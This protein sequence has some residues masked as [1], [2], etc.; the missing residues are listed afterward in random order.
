MHADRGADAFRRLGRILPHGRGFWRF[1]QRTLTSDAGTTEQFTFK[2]LPYG[3]YELLTI[4][5]PGAYEEQLISQFAEGYDVVVPATM[6]ARVQ[7]VSFT[8]LDAYVDVTLPPEP[9]D[10][11]APGIQSMAVTASKEVAMTGDRLQYTVNFACVPGAD[12]AGRTLSFNSYGSRFDIDGVSLSL[13]DTAGNRVEGAVIEDDHIVVPENANILT[14]SLIVTGKIDTGLDAF[15]VLLTIAGPAGNN[16][17]PRFR[18]RCSVRDFSAVI[19]D[20]AREDHVTMNGRGSAGAIITVEATSKTDPSRTTSTNIEVGRYGYW[21]GSVEL[22]VGT[23]ETDI[24]TITIKD[25]GSNVLASGE[26]AYE[27]DTVLP[28]QISIITYVNGAKNITVGYPGSRKDFESLNNAVLQFGPDYTRVPIEVEI[29]F[30]DSDPDGYG[31]TDARRVHDPTLTLSFGSS[32]TPNLYYAFYPVDDK[33]YHYHNTD[34]DLDIEDCHY[35]TKYMA[36]FPA[37]HFGKFGISY[38]LFDGEGDFV[39]PALDDHTD[40]TSYATNILG[41]PSAAA[42]QYKNAVIETG[43]WINQYPGG[44][45]VHEGHY[46]EQ[47]LWSDPGIQISDLDEDMIKKDANPDP[48][49]YLME[50]FEDRLTDFSCDAVMK[51][52]ALDAAEL[53]AKIAE[54]E[55]QDPCYSQKFMSND[56]YLKYVDRSATYSIKYNSDSNTVDLIISTSYNAIYDT[57]AVDDGAGLFEEKGILE[58]GYFV[59]ENVDSVVQNLALDVASEMIS[60][61]T[62]VKG[63]VNDILSKAYAAEGMAEKAAKTGAI[64]KWNSRLNVAGDVVGAGV[65]ALNLGMTI[66]NEVFEDS[67]A[68]INL[69]A[70]T[71]E[72][73]KRMQDYADKLAGKITCLDKNHHNQMVSSEIYNIKDS[74]LNE[75]AAIQDR[76]RGYYKMNGYVEI[77]VTAT[78]FI[79]CPPSV[80]GAA[81][82]LQFLAKEAREGTE[83][84]YAF[85]QLKDM[86][87]CAIKFEQQMWKAFKNGYDPNLCDK[88]PPIEPLPDSPRIKPIKIEIEP[89]RVLDPS[90]VVYE[91]LLSNPVEGVNVEIEYSADGENDWV[92][93]DDAPLYN[94][95]QSSYVTGPTGYY[96]WDVPDGFWRVSYQKD[97]Y[98]GGAKIY[99][100][101]MEVPPIWLDVN[102]PM[103]S[104]DQASAAATRDADGI[105]VV[106]TK[107]VKAE[108]VTAEKLKITNL[109]GDPVPVVFEA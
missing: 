108:D 30:D 24:F 39:L 1:D 71:A 67:K 103:E 6:S 55:A 50:P 73:N 33:T 80:P 10:V 101:V 18:T 81:S 15:A 109:Q 7:N 46:T 37:Y 75:I 61:V 64:A 93:W 51:W 54:L 5:D 88:I 100:D 48:D 60:N 28:T 16:S 41:Y 36:S 49:M 38:E 96:Q 68:I 63:G 2:T 66:K 87:Q 20:R 72:Y 82:V 59:S 92:V 35:S 95:Q 26:T 40:L 69:N 97:G 86:E 44:E 85:T 8:E 43:N 70:L 9:V 102:Q 34:L 19:P 106:F 22:P 21:T 89:K 58:R 56:S 14:G 105:M 79:P 98:N 83:A 31:M 47:I 27:S 12:E 90:G 29:T 17:A 23:V 57:G 52:K 45:Y 4:L 77:A 42:Q 104:L 78:S 32:S 74:A 62:E 76:Y 13:V 11:N 25:A 65:N 84:W 3:S 91:G 53:E 99:S 94:G 107:P